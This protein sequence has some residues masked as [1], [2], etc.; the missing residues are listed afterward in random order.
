METATQ[1]PP[2]IIKFII[3][4]G[5]LVIPGLT[6]ADMLPGYR[7]P[8]GNGNGSHLTTGES[9]AEQNGVT[10]APAPQEP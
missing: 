5:G 6:E 9:P 1:N 2:E 4:R 7:V 10:S 3:E 8:N